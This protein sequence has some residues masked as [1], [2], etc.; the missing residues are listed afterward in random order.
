MEL[1]IFSLFLWQKSSVLSRDVCCLVVASLS[2]MVQSVAVVGNTASAPLLNG[3]SDVLW[4]CAIFA[5]PLHLK[6]HDSCKS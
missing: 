3:S 6:S 4:L 1:D 2:P 5:Y